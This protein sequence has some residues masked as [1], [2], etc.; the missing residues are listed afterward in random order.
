M[1]DTNVIDWALRATDSGFAATMRNALDTLLGV[2]RGTDTAKTGIGDLGE[3]SSTAAGQWTR[4]RR[5][6]EA[7]YTSMGKLP[8]KEVV[9]ELDKI[10]AKYKQL[11]AAAEGGN[12]TAASAMRNLIGQAR[13]TVTKDTMGDA[14]APKSAGASLATKTA[15]A[16]TDGLKTA[17]AGLTAAF[18]AAAIAT[19]IREQIDLADKLDETAQKAAVS[20]KSLSTLVYAAKFGGTDMEGLTGS[21]IK[22]S[23]TMFEADT[24]N[25]KAAATFQTL[26]VS[27]KDQEGKLR[28]SDEVLVELAD[29]FSLMPDN[30]Q[31]AALAMELFGKFGAQMLPFLNLGAAGI[32]KLR[33][34]ARK[35]GLEITDEAAAAAGDLNDK[36][37]KMRGQTEGAW[38]QFAMRLVPTLSA[39]ADGFGESAKSGGTLNAIMGGVDV[40]LKAIIITVASVVAAFRDLG[41]IVGGVS[42]AVM[43]AATGDFKGAGDIL[44]M[45][46]D[47]LQK[48]GKAFEDYA[49]KVWN[50]QTEKS[51]GPKVT[52][53]VD[54][55]AIRE[56]NAPAAKSR[57]SE[58]D[59]ELDRQKLAHQKMTAEEGT[60][61]EFSR[62]RERDF[63]K[64]K[65]DMTSM[66]SDERFAVEKKYLSAVQAINSEAFSAQL[67]QQKNQMAELEK[68]YAGQLV[69]AQEIAERTRQAYGADSR[70]YA[71]AQRAVMA[72]QRQA[73]DQRRAMQDLSLSDQRSVATQSIEIQRQQAQL[74]LDMGLVSRQQFLTMEL[75][76]QDQLNEIRRQALL[77]KKETTDPEK[78]PVAYAAVLNQLLEQERSFALAK[79]KLQA[80]LQLE[81]GGP[82]SGVFSSLEGSFSSAIDGMLNRAQTWR[83]SMASI[84]SSVGTT[85][86][87]EMAVKPLVAYVGS[88]ARRLFLTESTTA[89]ET[90]L[91]ATAAGTK[92]TASATAAGVQVANNAVVAGSGAAASQ[93]GIPIIGPGMAAVAMAAMLAVVLGMSSS[94]KSARSGYDIPAGLNPVTQLHEEEMVLPARYANVIRGMA[95]GGD[96]QDGAQ[97]PFVYAPQITAMDSRSVKRVLEDHSQTLVGIMKNN[98]R[99]VSR[100]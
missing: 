79:Q 87:Q 57:V 23:K 7:L 20:A 11:A 18:T 86:I 72:V 77:R 6:L 44:G 94:I 27:V 21:L 62:E 61:V 53:D 69:I 92:A 82:A 83:Q 59:N 74:E 36:L 28:A 37:D 65:L 12:A 41:T 90:T 22:L 98:Q 25:K 2:K 32:E 81:K 30:A 13:A 95:S 96:Q 35:M 43:T 68:N 38:R 33:E 39:A 46:T 99:Q 24:G 85:F 17:V 70:Q 31:K 100:G 93:A 64:S 88:M 56:A 14:D 48:N 34:E 54:V 71:D 91:E 55:S 47:D 58:W 49:K 29:K 45:M 3:A 73:D 84:F 40:T 8:S 97:Q 75:G 80:N 15:S 89:A 51:D 63:W 26:G 60:F 4:H 76:Y 66:S 5:E 10:E 67:A 19:R 50:G 52:K 16:A 9:A 1:S 78:D 42:A